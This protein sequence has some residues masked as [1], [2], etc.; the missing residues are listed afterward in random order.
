LAAVLN[1]Y[2]HQTA[3]YPYGASSTHARSSNAPELLLWHSLL[4]AQEAGCGVY[5]L[6]GVLPTENKNHP[7]WGYTFF[8]QGFGGQTTEFIGSFDLPIKSNLY[9]P[10]LWLEKTRRVFLSLLRNH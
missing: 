7:Y 1:V 3:Y 8:K 4:A 9:S 5:D 6:W 2:S 10:L